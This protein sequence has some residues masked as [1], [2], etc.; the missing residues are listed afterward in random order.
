MIYLD[1]SWLAKLYVDE[2]G[3]GA[4]RR[5]LEGEHDILVS[6]LAYVEFHA[7][8]ARRRREGA[9]APRSAAALLSR[10]RQEWTDRARIPVS[11]EVVVRAAQLV[12]AHPLRTLDALHLASALLVARGASEPV[13]IGAADDRLLAAARATGLE[14]LATTGTE[15]EA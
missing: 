1:T 13:R 5:R 6:E 2:E 12:E 9:L 11:T 8:V 4:V 7:A 3:A 15:E 10:F 14:V